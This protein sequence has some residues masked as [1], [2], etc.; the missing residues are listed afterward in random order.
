MIE[1]RKDGTYVE[2][3]KDGRAGKYEFVDPQHLRI[4][5]DG[6]AGEP[7]LSSKAIRSTS[8]IGTAP[9]GALSKTAVAQETAGMDGQSRSGDNLWTQRGGL[10]NIAFNIDETA[11]P[12]ELVG[13]PR[14]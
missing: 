6:L 11:L 8:A 13:A 4:Q 9:C 10:S 14:G 12:P 2:G 1:F 5:I 3:E 7:K